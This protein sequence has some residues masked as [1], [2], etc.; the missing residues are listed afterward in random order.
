MPTSRFAILFATALAFC[1]QTS[2]CGH[3]SEMLA[4]VVGASPIILVGKIVS[5]RKTDSFITQKA[6]NYYYY[7]FTVKIDTVLKG[8]AH[9]KTFDVMDFPGTPDCMD[10]SRNVKCLFFLSK[11]P[12]VAKDVTD[13]MV[14]RQYKIVKGSITPTEFIDEKATQPVRTFEKKIGEIV[15]RELAKHAPA[16]AQ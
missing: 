10:T 11:S 13:W 5:A 7:V 14:E 16:A 6:V 2:Y 15:A 3:P 1:F 4:D 8:D 12:Y 9:L